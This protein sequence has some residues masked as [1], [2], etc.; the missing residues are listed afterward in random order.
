MANNDSFVKMAVA[1][2]LID[3]AIIVC[4]IGLVVLLGCDTRK[5]TEDVALTT[6]QVSSQNLLGE[7]LPLVQESQILP[8]IVPTLTI[9][10]TPKELLAANFRLVA[11]RI[12]SGK[13]HENIQNFLF[14][15]K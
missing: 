8:D 12:E 5:P 13:Y 9:S 11:Q 2:F 10:V 1:Y 4:V 6:S 14:E 7:N 3:L 15:I